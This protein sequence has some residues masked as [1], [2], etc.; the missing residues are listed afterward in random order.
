MHDEKINF[1]GKVISVSKKEYDY[2]TMVKRFGSGK[3]YIY[4]K[5]FKL[6]TDHND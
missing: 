2:E 6:C 3:D 4:L 5:G 1:D